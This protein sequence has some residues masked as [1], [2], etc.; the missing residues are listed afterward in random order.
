MSYMS[1]ALGLDNRSTKAFVSWSIQI[2]HKSSGTVASN[3]VK[4]FSNVDKFFF[5]DFTFLPKVIA[6][7]LMIRLYVRQFHCRLT[8]ADHL[9]KIAVIHLEVQHFLLMGGNHSP[10]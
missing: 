3:I 5:V 2:R 4:A 7:V 1:M 8:H 9:Q 6:K 10:C